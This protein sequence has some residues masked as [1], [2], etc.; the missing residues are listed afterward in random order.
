MEHLYLTVRAPKI[1][2]GSDV[3]FTLHKSNA[4]EVIQRDF[5]YGI[6]LTVAPVSKTKVEFDSMFLVCG[7]DLIRKSSP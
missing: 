7:L 1:Q 3:R 2:D 6:D 5:E 4:F